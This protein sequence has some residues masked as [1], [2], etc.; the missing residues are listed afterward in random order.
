[1]IEDYV[2]KRRIIVGRN[3][4]TLG[5]PQG[6]VLEPTLWNVLYEDLIQLE[7]PEEVTS[8]TF[9]DNLVVIIERNDIDEANRITTEVLRE[10]S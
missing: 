10:I 1:M 2:S 7:L 5:V 4:D 9:A 6:S 8:L 3:H